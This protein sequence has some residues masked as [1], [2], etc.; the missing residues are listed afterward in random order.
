MGLKKYVDHHFVP[1]ENYSKQ[2][3]FYVHTLD[4]LLMNFHNLG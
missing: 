1:I 4:Q 2:S 3:S